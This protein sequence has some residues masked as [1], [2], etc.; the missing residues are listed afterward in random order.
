[1]ATCPLATRKK[2]LE[3]AKDPW[4]MSPIR[5]PGRLASQQVNLSRGR[6]SLHLSNM[7]FPE[8]LTGI[9]QVLEGTPL[10]TG[11][12][13]Y[14]LHARQRRACS[15]RDVVLAP[16]RRHRRRAGTFGRRRRHAA[17]MRA[18]PLWKSWI[19]TAEP[20]D[21]MLSGISHRKAGP[22]HG[23]R[24]S[25]N[26]GYSRIGFMGTSMPL[27]PPRAQTLRGP[28]RRVSPRL[29]SRLKRVISTRAALL[30]PK[31]AR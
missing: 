12:W 13:R 22:R 10:S 23:D 3:A 30:W 11:F 14:R 26:K 19:P 31:A 20:I 17:L 6:S 1:M 15:L 29:V 5:S 21:S 28:D 9:N 2:V 8:V 25:S 24:P 4:A 27:R 7:V 18:S 16:V